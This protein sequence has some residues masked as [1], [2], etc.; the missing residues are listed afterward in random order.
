MAEIVGFRSKLVAKPLHL[1]LL[2]DCVSCLRLLERGNKIEELC[3]G[4]EG[5]MKLVNEELVNQREENSIA[6]ALVFGR[7]IGDQCE[8]GSLLFEVIDRVDEDQIV[9]QMKQLSSEDDE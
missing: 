5:L 6:Q 7:E 8:W 1:Q 2:D 4:M 3:L 9:I